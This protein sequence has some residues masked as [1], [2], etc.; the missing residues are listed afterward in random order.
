MITSPAGTVGRESVK[1]YSRATTCTRAGAGGP[2]AGGGVAD[3]PGVAAGAGAD[4]EATCGAWAGEPDGEREEA[5]GTGVAAGATEPLERVRSR[6][7]ARR[8]T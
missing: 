8:A 6:P 4:P 3:P 7:G 2:E 1:L 5:G